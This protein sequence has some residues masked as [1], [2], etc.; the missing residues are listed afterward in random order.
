MKIT[1]IELYKLALP[2]H[3]S[4]TTSFGTVKDKQTVI[5]KLTADSGL[6]GYGEAPG[7]NDPVYLYET[8]GTCYYVVKHY[9]APLLLSKQVKSAKELSKL[10]S[11]IKGHNFA[12][13]SV[14]TA[15]WH[16]MSQ[17][18]KTYLSKLLGGTK[19]RVAVGESIGIKAN[20]HELLQSVEKCLDEG[21]QR[22]KIKIQPGWD[23]KAV[24]AIRKQFPDINLMVDANSAYTIKDIKKLQSIDNYDL[25]MIEQPLAHDDIIDHATLQKKLKT[26]ICLDESILSAEDA[27]KAIEI[28][29]CKIIN[30][31]PPRVG[32]ILESKKIHDLCKKHGIPVWCGGMLETGIGRAFNMAV[33]SLPNFSLP[34]DMSPPL[35]FYTD[36]LVE[37]T[38]KIEK[39][40][41]ISVS[42]EPGL[43]YQV[44]SSRI[45]KY[46]IEKARFN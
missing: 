22:V 43:G 20:L 1:R 10:L 29:A 35:D 19:K 30:I 24:K 11:P 3:T 26:P 18:K 31:K 33:A 32:G 42:Q 37:P 39:G 7:L 6:E 8:S 17:K 12:K 36:D 46:T 5:V 16:I 13:T 38:L 4:F 25:M 28:G 34:S 21:Y 14:E 23:I 45:N 15:F 40:G 44:M 41:Y 9:I 27:R 2:M